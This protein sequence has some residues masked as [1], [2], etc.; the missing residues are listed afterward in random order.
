MTKTASIT[1][2]VPVYNREHLVE[3]ALDSIAAQDV[4]P[5]SLIVVDNNSSDHSRE[6]VRRWAANHAGDPELDI[7]I[8]SEPRP[9]A[10]RARQTGLEHVDTEWVQFFDSDDVMAPC[11]LSEALLH[12]ADAD[13]VC[14]KRE[15]ISL[16]GRNSICP[17]RPD[18]ILRCHLYNGML[19]TQSY[20]VRTDF[21]KKAGGWNPDVKV[22]DDFELGLRLLLASPRHVALD[23]IG[24]TVYSQEE[25]IT[26]TSYSAKNGQWERIIDLMDSY[27][28]DRSDIHAMLDYRRVN[29]AALYT[30]EGNR[31][32]GRRLLKQTL[33]KTSYS[34]LTKLWLRILYIYTVAGGRGAYLL[35]HY[36][37]ICTIP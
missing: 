3:R 21:I 34:A 12:S 29:L 8:L 7:R 10:A 32:S 13:M 9:G 31:T 28:A 25:S 19:S 15:L 1:V 5:L 11:I 26:G 37:K 35:W 4:R 17:Y 36:P 20:M 33:E 6:T 27:A 30:R 23:R 18:D 14:W 22:W 16:S 24:A 2:V